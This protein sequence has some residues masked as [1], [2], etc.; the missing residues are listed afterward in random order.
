MPMRVWTS[1]LQY[2]AETSWDLAVSTCI[3][4]IKDPLIL[5]LHMLQPERSPR[6]T[7]ASK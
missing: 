3:H 4:S 7:L 6:S 5:H 2:H 1:N